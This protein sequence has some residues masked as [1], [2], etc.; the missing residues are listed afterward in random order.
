MFLRT[1]ACTV[2]GISYCFSRLYNC[3]CSSATTVYILFP[4]SLAF[5]SS[6]L[7]GDHTA[8]GILQLLASMLFC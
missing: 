1:L 5:V 2:A 4:A 6:L 7:F 8:V 3:C